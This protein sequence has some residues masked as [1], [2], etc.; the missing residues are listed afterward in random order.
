M[1]AEIYLGTPAAER[2]AIVRWLRELAE[3]RYADPELPDVIRVFA[4][5][6]ESG[7][8][9]AS[10][11]PDADL[12]ARTAPEEVVDAVTVTPSVT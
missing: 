4:N 2:A 10:W 7:F 11:Q 6:I 12:H 1:S 5:C 3:K 8:H 9:R